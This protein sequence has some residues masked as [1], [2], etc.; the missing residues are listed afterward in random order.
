MRRQD[1]GE[2]DAFVVVVQERNF[3]R[4]AQRS[5]RRS[6]GCVGFAVDMARTATRPNSLRVHWGTRRPVEK[7]GVP[8]SGQIGKTERRVRPGNERIQVEGFLPGRYEN[9]SEYQ[10]RRGTP[11][12]SRQP[13]KNVNQLRRSDLRDRSDGTD[14]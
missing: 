7:I 9:V 10:G 4:A 1:F 2:L 14:E 13:R 11:D 12:I 3:T 8:V 6:G 5:A